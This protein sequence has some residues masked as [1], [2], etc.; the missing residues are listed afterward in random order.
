M[1]AVTFQPFH[2]HHEELDA[3]QHGYYQEFVLQIDCANN[4]REMKATVL[5]LLMLHGA[6]FAILTLLHMQAMSPLNRW[7]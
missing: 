6:L 7:A 4:R 2:Y 1:F 5:Y 3:E